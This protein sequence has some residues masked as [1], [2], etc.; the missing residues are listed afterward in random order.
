MT[1]SGRQRA[2]I[3]EITNPTR[4]VASTSQRTAAVMAEVAAT[5]E[6][7]N[8]PSQTVSVALTDVGEVTSAL[9]TEVGPFLHAMAQDDIYG[10][11][12]EC[13]PRNDVW[14]R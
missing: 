11:H 5:T 14:R 2:A 13:L 8:V 4:P 7:S 1:A 3:R 10:R 6:R 9:R 12:Y